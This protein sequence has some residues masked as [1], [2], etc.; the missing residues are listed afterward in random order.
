MRRIWAAVALCLVVCVSPASA[1][2]GGRTIAQAPSLAFGKAVRG[3]LYDGAF[4]SGYSVAFWKASLAKGDRMTIRTR[5]AGGDTPPCQI[6]YHAG[7]R[8]PQRRSD[9]AAAGSGVADA[10]RSARRPALRSGDPER[11]L[12]PGDDE[13]GHL[14]IR[15]AS[16]LRRP[17]GAAVHLHGVG[18]PPRERR[19]VEPRKGGEQ[20]RAQSSRP[21][22]S[23]W[24]IAQSVVGAAGRHRRDR[25]RGPAPVAPQSRP[26]RQPG[27]DPSRADTQ[28]EMSVTRTLCE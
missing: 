17:R 3:R 1:A 8:R 23:L 5:S 7:H 22:Q 21:G 10:A 28:A 2:V 25:V 20:E 11:N 19:P 24:V 6:L 16:V 12:R 9:D 26:D 13:R 14:L 27:P 18:R 15:P 4:Y